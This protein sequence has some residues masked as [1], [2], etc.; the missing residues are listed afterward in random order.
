LGTLDLALAPDEGCGVPV[1]GFREV[2]DRL[3]QLRDAGKAGS[4]QGLSGEDAEPDFHLVEPA[5]RGWGEV[6]GNVRVCRQPIVVLL[7]GGEVVEDDMDCPIGRLRGDQVGHKGLKI[8]ASL[9]LR[10]L[11]PNDTGGHFERG[12]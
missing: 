4:G 8:D 6:E 12:E 10:S 7:V 1:V 3:D 9:G 5:C 11:S 2:A